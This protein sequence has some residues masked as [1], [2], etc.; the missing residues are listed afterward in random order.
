[1]AD[2]APDDDPVEAPLEANVYA[3][4][5]QIREIAAQVGFGERTMWDI[6]RI[7]NVLEATA[8]DVNLASQLY[9][10]DFVAT[11]AAGDRP[12]GPP[13]E[14]LLAHEGA[15]EANPA[16][17]ADEEGNDEL[18]VELDGM[19]ADEEGPAIPPN[20]AGP[21]VINNIPAVDELDAHD[22]KYN[23]NEIREHRPRR[24]RNNPLQEIAI[25]RDL[26]EIFGRH[27][28]GDD[29]DRLVARIRESVRRLRQAEP[30]HL[31]AN[32][33][34][35]VPA[36]AVRAAAAVFLAARDMESVSVSDEDE[37]G[38]W[39]LVG[40]KLANLPQ[41]RR[42][43]DPT[44]SPDVPADSDDDC[45]LSDNDWLWEPTDVRNTI[46]ISPPMDLLWGI[47]SPQEPTEAATVN[48][49]VDNGGSSNIIVAEDDEADD[50]NAASNIGSTG[51]PR[52][53][54]GCSF[55]LSDCATG[56]VVQPPN[57]DDIAYTTWR[58]KVPLTGS[59][60]SRIPPPYHCRSVSILLSIVTGLLYTGAA[61]QGT[62]V[63]C[64][65]SRKPFADLDPE[66]RRR[67]FG[68][69]LADA[70]SS[71][72]L[73]AAKSSIARKSKAL[74]AL[75]LSQKPADIRKWQKLARKL[76]LCPTSSW[77]TDPATGY[78]RFAGE[79]RIDRTPQIKT[80]FTNVEDLHS[81]V[82]SNLTFFTRSGGCALFLETLLRIH[83][84]GAVARMIRHARSR[85]KMLPPM[86]VPL[87]R[88]VCDE[89]HKKRLDDNPPTGLSR[90]DLAN[91]VGT[92]PPGHECVSIELLSLLLTGSVHSTLK[93]WSTG[94][95]GLGLLSEPSQKVC[96]GLTRPGQPVWLLRGPTCYSV[97]WLTGSRDFDGTD[98]ARI[99]R[100]G[101]VATLCHWNCWYE[102]R[103]R[104]DFRLVT[105]RSQW[106]PPTRRSVVDE[107]QMEETDET[108]TQ[109][110][111]LMAQ[112]R[113][114]SVGLL[115][116][117]E[118]GGRDL[119]E[120]NFSAE[121]TNRL[122]IHPEDQ[123]LYPDQY[124]MWRYDMH[125][126]TSMDQKPAATRWK[127][128]H[129]LSKRAQ[130]LVHVTLGPKINTILWTRWP[131]A[132]L[133]RFQPESPPPVV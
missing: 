43:S 87:I 102:E 127:P 105:V 5:Q 99:D 65:T 53:W 94:P 33:Q 128:F 103:R 117:L 46:P 104:T 31:P 1:M 39:K 89:K 14:A 110:M 119:V 95:L 3:V 13:M 12:H 19:D 6:G 107:R 76:R 45:Y 116:E 126:V 25:D 83:G 21:D 27:H 66:Q 56:L 2:P 44:S 125:E 67:E 10:D 88:C 78:L 133:E 124:Q 72:L 69:R 77:D 73:I 28:S 22:E 26:L 47:P 40:G 17:A 90:A 60:R 70:L 75:K 32:G 30:Q 112:R 68:S 23:N 93:G 24:S 64:H 41:K 123:K 120:L 4:L 82:L 79:R 42:R 92:S 37:E 58:K 54:L 29:A 9:W 11:H 113:R 131:S 36:A 130:Q 115:N 106:V 85:A 59:I 55:A 91:M 118:D 100:P 7:R 74:A 50:D 18:V 63:S 121:E 98:F 61:P 71:L 34:P 96:Q 51:I 122:E 20:H 97:L 111:R 48:N 109:T 108:Q 35:E 129:R 52:T 16:Q 8:G 80:S 62:T 101:A 132:N 84:K 114:E 15:G 38:G 86:E 49:E 81:Y 57:E